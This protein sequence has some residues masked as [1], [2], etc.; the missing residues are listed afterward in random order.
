MG[1]SG[2]SIDELNKSIKINKEKIE[3]LLGV[4]SFISKIST[5]ID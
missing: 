4:F 5:N 3:I 1:N 2:I